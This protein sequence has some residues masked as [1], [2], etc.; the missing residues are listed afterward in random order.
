MRTVVRLFV[1]MLNAWRQKTEK[2]RKKLVI[3]L[4]GES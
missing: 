2:E 3:N 1:V 4:N